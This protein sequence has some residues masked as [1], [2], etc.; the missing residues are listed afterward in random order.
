MLRI[1]IFLILLLGTCGY[2]LW[3][4]GAPERIAA[5]ALLAATIGSAIF[6]SEAQARFL[7][8]EVGIFIIDVLLLAVLIAIMLRADR[9]WPILVSALHLCTVGAH[10][11]RFIDPAMIRVTYVVMVTAWSWPMVIALGIGTWRHRARL[12]AYGYDRAW[13]A[14]DI[15]E[16][17]P[18]SAR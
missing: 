13:S 10:A 16:A 7:D 12:R 8:V 5:A 11:L 2:A 14:P 6:R 4:G 9:G 15:T 3:R 18:A 1:A 17:S